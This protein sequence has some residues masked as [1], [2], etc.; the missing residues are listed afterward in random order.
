[1]HIRLT[2]FDSFHEKNNEKRLSGIVQH[3][4]MAAGASAGSALPPHTQPDY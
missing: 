3:V 4:L 1:M 2:F